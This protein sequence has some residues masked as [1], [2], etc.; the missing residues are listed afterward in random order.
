MRYLCIRFYDM[1]CFNTDLIRV[2]GKEMGIELLGKSRLYADG[3]TLATPQT[4][5]IYYT[6]SRMYTVHIHFLLQ[7][8]HSQYKKQPYPVHGK[9]QCLASRS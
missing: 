3:D 6:Q 5:H 4:Q 7:G 1:Y 8:F 2:L 9:K